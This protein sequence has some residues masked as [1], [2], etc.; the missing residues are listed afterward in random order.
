MADLYLRE[1]QLMTLTAQQDAGKFLRLGGSVVGLEGQAIAKDP[2]TQEGETLSRDSTFES[3]AKMEETCM[4]P[5]DVSDCFFD[6]VFSDGLPDLKRL[7]SEKEM[8][9]GLQEQAKKLLAEDASSVDSSDSEESQPLA[10]ESEA[11]MK[12]PKWFRRNPQSNLRREEIVLR[13]WSLP[14]HRLEALGSLKPL[15]KCGARGDY[16]EVGASEKL[17]AGLFVRRFGSGKC[18]QLCEHI[19]VDEAGTGHVRCTRRCSG[20]GEHAN[21]WCVFH[22]DDV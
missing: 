18:D 11:K 5:T 10:D 12:W 16:S 1:A 6:D 14:G 4:Q 2:T 8:S 7:E 9:A 13:V 3:M 21:H 17:S 22:G 15:P 20:T 19:R